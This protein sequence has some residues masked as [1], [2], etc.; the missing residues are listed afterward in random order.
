[1]K[2]KHCLK[3]FIIILILIFPLIPFSS[4]LADELNDDI[5]AEFTIQMHDGTN[6][7]ITAE[8]DVSRFTLQASDITY[9]GS[10]IANI[11][12]ESS[13][14]GAIKYALR[15]AI[16]E[17]LE[18]IF[19]NADVDSLVELP[20][21][22][23]NNFI[24]SYSVK[25]NEQYF[26]LNETI[27]SFELINGALD[28]DGNVNYTFNFQAKTGWNN[29]FIIIFGEK[30]QYKKVVGG[31]LQNNNN[32]IVWTLDN[33]NGEK[34]S[35]IGSLT[36]GSANPTSSYDSE[37]INIEFILDTKNDD[38]ILYENINFEIIDI[39]NYDFLPSFISNLDYVTSDG[40]RL[41]I[42]NKMLDW[43]NSFYNS[44][45]SPIVDISKN[46]IDNS[47][48]N[49]T[50]EYN[51]RWDEDTSI[52]CSDCYDTDKMDTN[53]PIIAQFY[54][55]NL[56][57]R[58]LG[59]SSKAL[60]GLVNTGGIANIS[61]DDIN[62]GQGLDNIG[63]PYNITILFPENIGLDGENTY[64]WNDTILFEGFISSEKTPE[65]E[66]QEVDTTIE[67]NFKNSDLNI[68][69]LFTGNPELNF[70]MNVKE[71]KNI[72]ISVLPEQFDLPEKLDLNYLN[73]DAFRLCIQE[74]VFSNSQVE[75]YLEN[76]KTKF[77]QQFKNIIDK[78]SVNGNINRDIFDESTS[79]IV[80]ISNM[81]DSKPVK[82]QFYADTI[83]PVRFNFSVIPPAVEI[84]NQ[85]FRLSGME[86]KTVI[87][88]IYFPKGLD[89]GVTDSLNKAKIKQTKDKKKYIE[90]S[91][92]EN[93]YNKTS[94]VFCKLKPTGLYLVSLFM[95]CIITF[96]I[97]IILVIVI[98]ILRKKRKFRRPKI[99]TDKHA[100]EDY[101]GYDTEDYYVPP[102]PGSK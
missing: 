101:G 28:M 12:S 13:I 17:Q 50:L 102:P 96:I 48:Y 72:N 32:E 8:I 82:T 19:E 90:M 21:N 23:N 26:G 91:F 79:Y 7:T 9:T 6:F 22:S 58:I 39:S 2:Y 38:S 76:G 31:E 36:I 52:N 27:N 41:F 35:K 75:N 83:Y 33:W 84:P 43:N 93:E 69:G 98:I 70:E 4:S 89:I 94:V 5:N 24:D 37:K 95:P 53:P 71:T 54:D 85:I 57:L 15:I 25:L 100:E 62:F 46:I 64:I 81:S 16:R 97:V 47:E 14:M 11:P 78:L 59:I 77:D 61:K 73:S 18:S 80:D 1:M 87:Y 65:Y 30:I 63:Y 67:I 10:E 3:I 34:P 40:I 49:K 68:L 51:F 99:K 92:S 42:K 55:E 86:N 45:I 88:K 60:F 56:V 29:T 74:N 44:T 66:K 20:S